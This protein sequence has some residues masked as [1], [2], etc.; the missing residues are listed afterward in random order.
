MY[1][2]SEIADKMDI[3]FPKAPDTKNKKKEELE[4]MQKEYGRKIMTMIVKK[5][6]KAKNE[7]NQLIASVA[8]KNIEEVEKMELKETISILG[9]ILRQDGVL[10]FFK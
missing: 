1:I 6:Y 8:E 3:E 4:S 5:I 9:S 10:S 7:I 2:L